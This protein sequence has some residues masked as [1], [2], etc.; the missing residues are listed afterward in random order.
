[1]LELDWQ[2]PYLWAFLAASFLL[3]MFVAV[4]FCK[5][6]RT[7]KLFRE[8]LE[9]ERQL[10]IHNLQKEVD[11]LHRELRL[12]VERRAAAEEKNGR[13]IHLEMLL[14]ER[15][16]QL[17]KISEERISLISK[18]IE[19]ESR[20][21]VGKLAAEAKF[22]EFQEAEAKWTELFKSLSYEALKNN[23][24]S[25]LDLAKMALEKFQEGARSDL[26][27]RQLSIHEL[28]K[29]VKESLERFD[30]KINDLEKARVGAYESIAQ[31]VR[32]MM[33]AQIHLRNETGNL[34]KALRT[35]TARGRWGEM[36]LKRVVEMAGMV[37]HCDFF[38]QESSQGEEGK[39]RPDLIVR[40]P[41]NK[42]IVIDAKTPLS[43]Y[44]EAIEQND[45]EKKR[46][47]FKEHARQ[48]RVHISALSKKAYQEQFQPTPEF[49]VLFLPGE[50]FF[51]A[52]LEH[53]PTLI[54]VGVE[55]GVILATPT[56]L[57]ALLRAVAYGW[58]QESVSVNAQ[59]ISE[60]GRDLYKR[61]AVM[62][63]HWRRMGKQLGGA[64]ESYN[65]AV[66][67]L[68]SRLL[69]AARQFNDLEPSL[70]A[71]LPLEELIPIDK[72]PR[73]LNSPEFI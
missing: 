36:Q 23:Q 54:E 47:L 50:I 58:R 48:V 8:K 56:T 72:V 43:A 65:Q 28:V 60:L 67:S 57:I 24:Q 9:T 53:D 32:S 66:G 35:P 39:L 33:E 64:V 19:I 11:E 14:K 73:V 6:C 49:V 62:A 68:E 31:Q 29:P 4:I 30:Q 69:V 44:L 52:A 51:S 25:F 27:R 61:L 42:N 5:S 22:K 34:V 40:L 45:E 2:S 16:E 7:K 18:Q 1:M 15:E 71:S 41:S 20:A 46:S 37:D 13:I 26:E 38:E 17:Q 63:D 10:F 59:K 70:T 21:E 12:E 3:L 55:Q